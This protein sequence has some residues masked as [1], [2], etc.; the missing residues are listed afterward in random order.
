MYFSPKNGVVPTTGSVIA[1]ILP[2][3]RIKGL[4]PSE[5]DTY[6]LGTLSAIKPFANHTVETAQVS[7]TIQDMFVLPSRLKIPKINAAF[8]G[9]STLDGSISFNLVIGTGAY[10]TGAA[11]FATGTYTLSGVPLDTFNNV[12][13]INGVVTTSAQATANSLS[14]QATADAAAITADTATNHV[15]A[16]AVGAVITLTANSAGAAGNSI[17]TFGSST[18]G[19]TVTANQATLAGG[20]DETGINVAGN[21]NS[22]TSGFCTNPAVDGDALFNIDIP[23]TL[24]NF[25]N[26]LTTAVAASG[27]FTLSGVPRTTFNNIYGFGS[28]GT[29]T[30]AQVTG[31]SLAVQATADAAAIT[32]AAIGITATSSGPQVL[33]VATTAGALGNF[34]T[35]S[36]STNG[37][38][39]IFT[40]QV[41]LAGGKNTGGS[42]G[43][44]L[45]PTFP[46]AVYQCGA[47]LTLRIVSATGATVTNFTISMDTIPQP[48]E[49]TFPSQVIEA[50]AAQPF[51]QPGGPASFPAPSVPV[52]GRD[53]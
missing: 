20:A 31:N 14:A 53:F 40:G 48:L 16:V 3:Q 47:I 15:T 29:V 42:A 24:A 26:A 13:T 4:S 51:G 45:I 17:T 52:P 38:D 9:I 12:Y 22:S 30:V 41:T 50:P 49:A 37:G 1:S 2:G 35:T 10:A 39:S 36:A 18:G 25:P 8:S 21:D 28:L 23:I 46:D 6:V 33:V 32:A 7:T 19:D 34:I 11:T 43:L 44:G 27:Y 5:S